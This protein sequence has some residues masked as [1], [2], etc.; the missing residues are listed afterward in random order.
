MHITISGSLH[1]LEKYPT[2]NTCKAKMCVCVRAFDVYDSYQ[3]IMSCIST[4]K[5]MG[6]RMDDDDILINGQP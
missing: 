5:Y 1:Y 3:S 4:M 6:H 2:I